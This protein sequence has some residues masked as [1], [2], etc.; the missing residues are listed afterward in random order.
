MAKTIAPISLP[1][2]EEAGNY[3]NWRGY[4]NMYFTLARVRTLKNYG[5]SHET[6]IKDAFNIMKSKSVN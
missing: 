2:L 6:T 1:E 3:N 4:V 5:I